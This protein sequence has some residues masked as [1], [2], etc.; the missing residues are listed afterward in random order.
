MIGDDHFD[1]ENS[2]ELKMLIGD[3]NYNKFNSA[4]RQVKSPEPDDIDDL[5]EQ[6][7]RKVSLSPKK[8]MTNPVKSV[9]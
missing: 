3:E 2:D 8:S 7:L 9:A 1:L 5:V 4:T 6:E